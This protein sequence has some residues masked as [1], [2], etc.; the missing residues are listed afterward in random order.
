MIL[1]LCKGI[2]S[3]YNKDLHTLTLV[4]IVVVTSEVV[5][6]LKSLEWGLDDLVF[7]T[8]VPSR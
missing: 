2:M 7:K 6:T 4:L 5:L 8:T 3:V 1:N